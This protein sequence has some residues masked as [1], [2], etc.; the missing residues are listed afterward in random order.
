MFQPA[1]HG[2]V[3][4]NEVLFHD[5][6]SL[7]SDSHEFCPSSSESEDDFLPIVIPTKREATGCVDNAETKRV[8][9]EKS[10]IRRALEKEGPPTGILSY[11]RK[12]TETERKEALDRSSDEIREKMDEMQE[13]E[14]KARLRKE[15]TERRQARE[16]KRLQRARMKNLQ[17]STGIRSP[18]GR[19]R[20]VCTHSLRI[21]T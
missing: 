9:V 19:K 5:G 15:N 3:D 1:A 16:R 21:Q 13:R 11:F 7:G 14:K 17:I 4:T 12:A 8:C 10:S 6:G 2:A 20:Q 18:G